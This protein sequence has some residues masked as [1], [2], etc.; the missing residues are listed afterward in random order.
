[1]ADATTT[2]DQRGTMETHNAEIGPGKGHLGIKVTADNRAFVFNTPM[3]SIDV[4]DG[5][6]KLLNLF[7]CARVSNAG[8]VE[9]DN[10]TNLLQLSMENVL[11]QVNPKQTPTGSAD[12]GNMT[13]D[14][15]MFDEY[16]MGKLKSINISLKN[17]LVSVE[18]DTSGGIQWKDEPIFEIMALPVWHFD[19]GTTIHYQ[20]VMGANTYSTTLKEGFST[21]LSFNMGLAPRQTIAGILPEVITPPEKWYYTYPTLAEYIQGD[22][23]SNARIVHRPTYN[24]WCQVQDET[25]IY[26]I[27]LLNIPR[28]LSNIKVNVGYHSQMV[29]NWELRGRTIHEAQNTTYFPFTGAPAP[30][31]EVA[32]LSLACGKTVGDK[33]VQD[34]DVSSSSDDPG[35]LTLSELFGVPSHKR[36]RKPDDL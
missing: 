17:F 13:Y 36:K 23:F 32:A 4:T 31:P 27:R 14:N 19:D 21:G 1:M 35:N 30:K 7:Q 20:N 28:G 9:L 26:M 6:W 15:S 34:G 33:C 18:R 11:G 3:P 10:I 24:G 29:V 16:T 8:I 25:Y 22:G 5:K 12:T 2:G